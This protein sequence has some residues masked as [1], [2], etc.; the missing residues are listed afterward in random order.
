MKKIIIFNVGS[1]SCKFQIFTSDL[2]LLGKGQVE[3]IGIAK[4]KTIYKKELLIIKGIPGTINQDIEH[5]INRIVIEEK[6]INFHQLPNYII[7]FLEKNNLV[8]LEDVYLMVHRVVNGGDIFK[9]DILVNDIILDE[10]KK[11]CSLAPLHNPFNIST[12]ES[13]YN[14]CPQAQQAVVFDT[15]FHSTITQLKHLYTIP[16]SFYQ[17]EKIR[18]YGA[19]GSSHH[20]ITNQLQTHLNKDSVNLINIHLGN[21]A[22]ICVIEDGKSFDTSMGFT[23]LAGLMMG[24]RTGDID[25]SIIFHLINQLK[26]DPKEVE[27]IFIKKSGLL[28]ISELSS[29]MRDIISAIEKGNEK[30]Y[31]ARQVFID[32]IV[33]YLVMYLN[34]LPHYDGIVFTGGIGENDHNLIREVINNIRIKHLVVKG[35]FT[36]HNEI[37]L[38]SDESSEIPI[39]IIPTN[40]E[41]YMAKIGKKLI[42]E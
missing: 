1:S 30:A 8:K 13:F 38:I 20:F 4:T 2:K 25:P 7:D 27:H 32:K 26:I 5:P 10:L 31:L 33:N 22:S 40:E 11:T 12:L 41:L 19:H 39:F 29:D 15:T 14:K 24:T 34:Q 9:N 16:L 3:R 21:G 28:G 37:N 17:N 18:K 42:G 23:P 36:N 35:T 6:D